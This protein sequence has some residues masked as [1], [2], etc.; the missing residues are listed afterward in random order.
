MILHSNGLITLNY[1]PATDILEVAY[2][3]LH[4][5]LLTEIKQSI[6]VMLDNIRN[7]DIKKLLLDSSKTLISVTPEE[8]KEITTYLVS[9][10][11]T[12]RIRKLARLQSPSSHV[13]HMAQNNIQ[14]VKTAGLLTFDLQ[15]F[16]DKSG[17]IAWLSN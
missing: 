3:D 7:Y 15:S 2:P 6:D 17:A 13:E 5:Y 9:G 11:K 8:T 16:T 4:G 10:L 1:N 12:T 14:H